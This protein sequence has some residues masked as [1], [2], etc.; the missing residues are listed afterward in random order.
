MPDVATGR[1]LPR[2]WSATGP[3]AA[4]QYPDSASAVPSQR[5]RVFVY[6]PRR[7][8]A[9]TTSTVAT[10]PPTMPY[11]GNLGVIHLRLVTDKARR[12]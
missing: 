3:R 6:S 4:M 1:Y 5:P 12:R 10:S 11:A 7:T 8:M 9:T 2:P